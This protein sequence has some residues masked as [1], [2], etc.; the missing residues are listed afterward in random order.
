MLTDRPRSRG[1]S[2]TELLTIVAMI[3]VVS[4]VTL[5]AFLQ[6]M[7]QYRIRAAASEMAASLRMLRAKA[8]ATRSDWRMTVLPATEQYRLSRRIS[9]SSWQ[10][11]GENGK[12]L[13]T[14]TTWE[15]QLGAVDILGGS[16]TTITFDRFGRANAGSIVLAVNSR[17]VAYNRYTIAVDTS[18]NVTVTP[19]KV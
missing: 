8:V 9:S 3:G 1:Y 15:K 19:S 12:R 10:S 16:P 11:L 6:I 18:G 13:P 17:W 14:G 4:M 2:L 7:P 5:P